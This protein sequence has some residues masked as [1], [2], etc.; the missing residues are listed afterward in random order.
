VLHWSARFR[1]GL[2]R[3]WKSHD[4]R[5]R[6][7]GEGH[8][9]RERLE[10]QAARAVGSSPAVDAVTEGPRFGKP[11]TVLPRYG[12]GAFRLLVTEA[13]NRRCA[14]DRRT[15]AACSRWGPH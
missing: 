12:Q 15:D 5:D 4:V 8:E 13:Y 10:L 7:G 14:I 1:N 11:G 3:P 9:V 6:N 2:K